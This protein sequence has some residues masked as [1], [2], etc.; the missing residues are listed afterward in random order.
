VISGTGIHRLYIGKSVWQRL[1]TT[2]TLVDFC[3]VSLSSCGGDGGLHLCKVLCGE[4]GEAQVELPEDHLVARERAGL[5]RKQKVDP[6]QLL[7]KRRRTNLRTLDIDLYKIFVCLFGD[8]ALANTIL[9]IQHLLYCN[10][11]PL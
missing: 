10:P 8:C 2:H 3:S 11:P 6:A 5:V 9:G 1:L 4:I 7:R